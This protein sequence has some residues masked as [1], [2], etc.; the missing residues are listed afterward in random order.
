M[1]P[2]DWKVQ[3]LG[4]IVQSYPAIIG[5]DLAGIVEA[6]GEN[7][8]VFFPFSAP[9]LLQNNL[10]HFIKEFTHANYC[11]RTK[12]VGLFYTIWT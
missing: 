3:D 6:V 7:V 2:V 9:P 10:L 12:S 11:Q 5:S 8:E 4:I 1:N